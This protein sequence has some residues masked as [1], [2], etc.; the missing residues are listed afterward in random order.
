MLYLGSH[1]EVLHY[2]RLK[3]E[4]QEGEGGGEAKERLMKF[5]VLSLYIDLQKLIP[6]LR[7]CIKANMNKKWIY[8][9]C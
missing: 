2:I 6:L 4:V 8:R 9:N 1:I 3:C 7:V 5:W